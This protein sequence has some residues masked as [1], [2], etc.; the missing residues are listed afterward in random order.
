MALPPSLASRLLAGAGVLFLFAVP[1]S[2]AQLPSQQGA[3]GAVV[4]FALVCPQAF[5]EVNYLGTVTST[6]QFYDL[7][8]DSVYQAPGAPGAGASQHTTLISVSPRAQHGFVVTLGRT[9]I[10]SYGGDIVNVQVTVQTTPLI[11]AQDVRFDV[12]ANYTGPGGATL[13]QTVHMAAQV[14][15]Y[16]IGHIETLGRVQKAGQF[17]TVRYTLQVTN[18]GVFPDVYQFRGKAP[19]GFQMSVPPSVYV[20]PHESRNATFSILTPH[21]KLY[22]LGRSVA[23]E[24]KAISTRGSAVYTEVGILSVSGAY[25]PMYWIPLTLV[26][27][28][29]AVIVTRKA[30]ERG[31]MRRLEQGRPRRVGLSPRQLVL[32]EELKRSDPEAYKAR[33]AQLEAVYAARRASYKE[34]HGEQVRNDREERKQARIEFKAQKKRRAEE[35]RQARALQKAQRKAAKAQAK[36]DAAE[37]RSKEKALA[38]KRQQLEKARAKQA[39][40]DAKQAAADAK[41]EAKAQRE[42]AKQ[43]KAE[44]KAARKP[45][46]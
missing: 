24:F 9:F 13:N 10:A 17:E 14:N 5:F 30:R 26:G 35:A 7:S 45:K 31:E 15:P 36:A 37:G 4:S 2:A 11:D 42:A 22:E 19:D 46:E 38:K 6:C 41:A 16:D 29:S 43:A 33:K 3:Q 39:K 27:V 12:L 34:V 8:R 20:P 40:V 32:L 18:D 23:F 44:A 25:V 1:L 28:I 21:D